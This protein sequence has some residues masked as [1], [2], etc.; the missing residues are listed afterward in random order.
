MTDTRWPYVV[1]LADQDTLAEVPIATILAESDG[2]ANAW[3]SAMYGYRAY[4]YPR[5]DAYEPLYQDARKRMWVAGHAENV[6]ID[7]LE[8]R[9][10]FEQKIM[11]VINWLYPDPNLR[12]D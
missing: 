6:A 12:P 1:V 8:R 7:R 3:A 4:C 10:Q 9:R 2:D 11:D 5:V